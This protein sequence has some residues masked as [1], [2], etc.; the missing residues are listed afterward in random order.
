MNNESCYIGGEWIRSASAETRPVINPATETQIGTVSVGSEVDVDRAVQAAARAFESY[1]TTTPQQRIELLGRVLEEYQKRFEDIAQSI[2][3]EVGCPI[4]LSRGLQAQTGLIHLQTYS[5]ILA[6]FDFGKDA[7]TTRVEREPIGVCGLITPWNW[8]INQLC[9]KIVPALAAGCTV[10]VKPSEVTPTCATILAEVFHAAGTPPGVF[11]LVHGEGP[12][13]GGALA[14]HPDVAMV[15]ITGSTRAGGQVARLA[16]DSIKRV[17]QELGGKSPFV[18]LPDA[19][20]AAATAACVEWI[21]LNTGQSCSAPTRLLVPES[22]LDDVV[23]AAKKLMAGAVIGDPASEATT[24]GPVVNKTQWDRV[25]RLIASGIAQGAQV[26][27]GGLGRPAHL[28]RGYYVQPTLFAGVSNDMEIAREEIFGP[29]LCVLTYRDEDEAAAIANDTPY[30][31]AGYVAGKDQ[32]RVRAM[33]RRL[34]AGSI[35]INGAGIDPMAPFGGYKRSGNGRE[36]GVQGLEEYLETKAM[37]GFPG[38]GG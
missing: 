26:V 2:R 14:A 10:V 22:M 24:M 25:Q 17:T 11:N 31:L 33:A 37:I 4:A 3:E 6:G 5:A 38:I 32:D 21:L 23:D 36:W 9:V 1:S 29:V 7:G 15:S 8:P 19:D 18:V 13:V 30:G 16:A 12:L 28:D 20:V 35:F 27:Y 34:R